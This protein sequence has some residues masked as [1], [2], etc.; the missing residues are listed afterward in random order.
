MRQSRGVDSAR[1]S[2]VTRG[3]GRGK[4]KGP[5]KKVVRTLALRLYKLLI[6]Y[7]FVVIV[8]RV[9]SASGKKQKNN[10]DGGMVGGSAVATETRI[11]IQIGKHVAKGNWV[12]SPHEIFSRPV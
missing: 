9:E 10:F 12:Q 8:P 11:R 4:G 5:Q 1:R 3:K 6:S 2:Q 7:R